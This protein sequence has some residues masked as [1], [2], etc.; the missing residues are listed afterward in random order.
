M[1]SVQMVQ[2]GDVLDC[3]REA[4]RHAGS[5]VIL[6]A[7]LWIFLLR[8]VTFGVGFMRSSCTSLATLAFILHV[9]LLL[10]HLGAVK[11]EVKLAACCSE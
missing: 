5:R 3:S 10:G 8:L 11:L 2:S 7:G 9:Q 1:H 4:I 6:T